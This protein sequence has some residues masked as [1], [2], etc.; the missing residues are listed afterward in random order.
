VAKSAVL[1]VTVL[2]DSKG[3]FRK[4]ES[5]LARV[6]DA[7]TKASAAIGVALGAAAIKAVGDASAL[8]ES[9]NAVNQVFGNAADTIDEFGKTAAESAGLSQR[10][11][12]Q[13]ATNTGA[14]LQNLG[15]DAQAAADSTVDLATRAADMASVF[16]TDVATALEAVN[17]GL[18]GETEPL[19]AFGVNVDDATLKAKALELGLYDGVGALDATAKAAAAEAVILQQTAAVSGDFANTSDSLANQQRV[20]GATLEDLSAELGT[21]LIPY[22]EEFVGWLQGAVEWVGENTGVTLAAAAALAAFSGTVLAINAALKAY[23]AIMVAVRFATI[24]WTAAQWYLNAAMYANPVGLIVL[25]IIALIAVIGTLI[26]WIAKNTDWFQRLWEWVKKAADAVSGALATAFEWVTEKIRGAV[27]WIR[28]LID[29]V[30]ELLRNPIG[31]IVDAVTGNSTRTAV[32]GAGAAGVSARA[33]GGRVSY[34]INVN[35]AV[36][37]A[38]G[39]ARAVQRVLDRSATRNGRRSPQ[40]GAW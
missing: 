3:D 12:N 10:E 35:A 32:A 37:D 20:L 26:Y 13:L 33:A 36:A 23:R 30:K 8:G 38:E 14:L 22:V 17:A 34:T 9:V 4:T 27:D 21:V 24:V 2:Q 7:A 31:G 18:R 40:A 11:F 19:R 5:D 29:K 39:T 25:G 15:Y 16:D 1:K 28:T 6:G